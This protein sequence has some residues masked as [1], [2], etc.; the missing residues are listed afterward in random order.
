MPDSKLTELTD[1]LT[2]DMRVLS[3]IN[4]RWGRVLGTEIHVA[5]QA[6]VAAYVPE[7]TVEKTHDAFAAALRIFD[8]R[9]DAVRAAGDPLLA[10]LDETA[11]VIKQTEDRR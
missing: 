9:M 10:A 4:R 5:E 8:E 2:E 1:E 7:R 11:R 6:M 3:E